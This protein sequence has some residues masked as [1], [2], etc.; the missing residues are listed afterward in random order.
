MEFLSEE[1]DVNGG[2][3]FHREF[4]PPPPQGP[5]KKPAT[6]PPYDAKNNSA[7]PVNNNKEST[8]TNNNDNNNNIDKNNNNNNING[9]TE[10]LTHDENSNEISKSFGVCKTCGEDI[11][12]K[13]EGC[14]TVGS[15]VSMF[16]TFYFIGKK[17]SRLNF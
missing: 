17:N 11:P 2:N 12:L 9:S 4:P 8:T 3:D 5:K 15:E 1:E 10:F 6:P 14:T 16:R 7:S 13:G